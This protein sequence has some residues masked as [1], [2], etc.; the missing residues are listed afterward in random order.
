VTSASIAVGSVADRRVSDR[1]LAVLFTVTVFVAAT[2]L[3]LVQPMV[4]KG[5]LPIFGGTPAVWTTSMLF[6]QAA[7][8]G[9]YG[10]A[11]ATLQ[12]LGP[13]RQSRVQLLI[14]SLALLALPLA[15][16][17]ATAGSEPIL[18]LFVLLATGVGLPFL[19]LS[20]A[21]P[22]LQRWFSVSGHRHANNAYV[23]YVASN[24]G[25]LA[26]LLAY[27]FLVE[28]NLSLE[29]QRLAWSALYIAFLGLTAA[30]VVVLFPIGRRTSV[31]DAD[32]DAAT[33]TPANQSR[34]TEAMDA[35][36]DH[37]VRGAR[38]RERVWWLALAFVPSSLML[39][40]TAYLTT[41]IASAPLLWVAP[42][43]LYLF[44]FVVAFS[45]YEAIATRLSGVLLPFLAVAAAIDMFGSV[46]LPVVLR[47]PLHLAVFTL[48]ALLCHGR[49]AAS[50]PP[51]VRLTEFYLTLAIG[52]VAGG[53]V[54]AIVAPALLDVVAEYPLAIGAAL[55]VRRP[56]A[57][58]AKRRWAFGALA[59][60]LF[61]LVA[62]VPVLAG[63]PGAWSTPAVVVLMSL[64]L[65]IVSLPVPF[66][67]VVT[68]VLT[69]SFLL[70]PAPLLTERNFFGLFRVLDSEG[71]HVLVHGTT[72]HG[73]QIWPP[74]A[75]PSAT[76]YYHSEGPMGDVVA[77]RPPDVVNNIGVLGLGSGGMA[78]HFQDGQRVTFYEIDP[79][80]VVVAMDA[81]YFT[82]LSSSG[83][84]IDVRVG[85]GRLL[86][87]DEPSASFDLL[88]MDAFS[89]DAVPT[90]L[91]T[92]EAFEL[93]LDRL[94]P[95]GILV[96]HISNRYLDL[97]PVVSAAARDL[98]L[99]VLERRD[100]GAE[101][102]NLAEERRPSRYLALA[103]DEALLSGLIAEGWQPLPATE[104]QP[105][106]DT[107][108]DLVSI[109]DW[110]GDLLR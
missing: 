85:D 68:I 93:Y 48:A 24:I 87:A 61:L 79:A 27:P 70:A 64:P 96:T 28:P 94:A 67:S 36:A 42:L 5:L 46:G 98:N 62:A 35:V 15:R 6:F 22:V 20:T 26:A 7:L 39:G 73:T 8:L 91:L 50:R 4:A 38:W 51:V 29:T 54:N 100:P 84:E 89:S 47:L 71:Q 78:A 105:W 103:R 55:L 17:E 9:G 66:G 1:S 45:R 58:S 90:H 41:D 72:V 11:H 63:Y 74:E 49:L 19:A 92:L 32:P 23:L 106:T 21:S 31:A 80:M 25:S 43:S 86:L 77:L 59:V 33:E 3:F 56:M 76:G 13:H 65:L 16:P 75:S 102:D 109:I 40:V 83:A 52:G 44:S 97:G 95:E 34:R 107:F 37:R 82:Y 18:S 101:S 57:G 69:A 14:L 53:I 88:M 2:L 10:L 108:S 12:R 30:C 104:R 81:R 60:L 110:S 99:T